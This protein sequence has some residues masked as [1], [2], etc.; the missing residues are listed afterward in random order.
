M[1][2]PVDEFTIAT[3]LLLLLQLPPLVPLLVNVVTEPA[4]KVAEPLTRPA[5]G[6]ALMVILDDE[7]ELP[8]VPLTVYVMVAEPAD[9]PVTTP[10]NGFTVAA[11]V[12]LLLQEPP[13]V[14]LLVNI[15][16]RPSHNAAAPLTVP[17]LGTLPMVTRADA[18]A[19]PQAEVTI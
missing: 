14:P 11:A 17:A 4:H 8:Q 12:L 9:T 3:R 16:V 2:T 19:V 7:A 1:I 10:V 6:R 18:L 13:P 15:A 5:L